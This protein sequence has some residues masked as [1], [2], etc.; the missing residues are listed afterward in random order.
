MTPGVASRSIV[1]LFFYGVVSVGLLLLLWQAIDLFGAGTPLTLLCV[2]SLGF[3][4]TR[5][6]F[7]AFEV[8][9]PPCVVFRGSDGAACE[10]R[11]RDARSGMYLLV[12]EGQAR[13]VIGQFSVM[14][15]YTNWKIY[16]SDR[17]AVCLH[18]GST[19]F[20]LSMLGSRDEAAVDEEGA[21][22]SAALGGLAV[23]RI[24]MVVAPWRVP[25]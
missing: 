15:A 19:C 10:T 22:L 16:S 25:W 2:V 13:L 4:L 23:K 24:P 12:N 8:A 6:V 18:F 14:V 11:L 21:R 17:V 3:C 9:N 5:I 20:P 7:L 1:M